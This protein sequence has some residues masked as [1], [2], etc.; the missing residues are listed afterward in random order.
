MKSFLQVILVALLFGLSAPLLASSTATVSGRVVDSL[1]AVV[2]NAKVELVE[3]DTAKVAESTR[4]DVNG[5]YVFAVTH[6]G[7]FRIRAEATSFQPAMSEQKFAG[8]THSA[9]INLTLSPSVV[10]QGIV[11]TATGVP[12]SELQTGA[13]ISV[14]SEES[15][16][17]RR[18][19][20]QELRIQPGV[21]LDRAGQIGAQVL[22]RVRGGPSDAN[23]VLVD[24]VPANDIGGGFDFANL[25]A[26]GYENVEV[27]RGPNSALFGS[28]ALA[29]VVSISTRRGT[30]ALPEVSYSIDGGTFGTYRQESSLGGAWKRFDYF[31]DVSHFNTQNSTANSEFNNGSYLGNV[32]FQILPGTELR[33]TVR[34]SVSAFNSANAIALYGIPDD[35]VSREQDTAFGV[36][37]ENRPNERWH[38]LL[39]YSGL[40]FRSEYTN[41]GP[42]GICYDPGVPACNDGYQVYL[43]NV[44]TIRGANGYQVTGQGILQYS[45]GSSSSPNLTDRNSVYA[46]SDFR[47]SSKLAALFGFRYESEDGYTT[48]S[49]ASFVRAIADRGNYSYTMQLNGGFW[50]RLYYTAGS[51]LERNAVFGFA[52]TPRASLAY[53]AAKPNESGL[54]NGTRLVFNFGKGIKEASIDDET[55]S[56]YRLLQE[57][58]IPN[59][60]EDISL[61]GIHP[62]K[63]ENSRTYDGGVQQMLLHGKA[64]V[65]LT[66]FH[67]EF[68]DQAEFV[69]FQGLADLGVPQPVVTALESDPSLSGVY[70][71]SLTYRAQGTELEA[72][73][74]ISHDLTVR[75]G[76]TYTDAVVQHSFSSDAL[77]AADKQ[78]TTNPAFPTIPIGAFAPL[79]GARPFRIAPNSGNVSAEWNNGRCL[80]RMTGTLVSRRDDSTFLYDENYQS[81]MLLPN[82][83]LD[84]SY[85]KLDL[86]GSFRVG[87]RVSAYATV[88]NLLNQH[89]YEAFGYPALPFTIRSGMQF[90]FGGES[91]KLR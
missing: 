83:N 58:S 32:G 60:Q 26:A 18:D 34:R 74:H 42:T 81:T 21:Q 28:D 1:G 79:V 85:Q 23:K 14:I 6:E 69:P 68:G 12:T 76:W 77:Q 35:G 11:V 65:S 3:N 31:T 62:F 13:S 72:E 9:E 7:R 56:I 15:L 8:G 30:T 59:G 37:L 44:V 88:E 49:Y 24:G 46:Q 64:R 61:Y 91:W 53:F 41:F 90:R 51:G 16:A 27:F 40:R 71:N 54:L 39:R 78:P 45:G 2:Q 43:G 47:V 66:Y 52:A 73:Y 63:A 48:T 75:G 29:S 55:N 84:P 80:V 57:P 36:T 17:T 19:V 50:D 70:A 25:S 89:Y 4:S 82:R 22:L 5:R 33:A 87:K 10:T 86:Y 20:E 67:N 38:N